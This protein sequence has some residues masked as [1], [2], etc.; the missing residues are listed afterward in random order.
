MNKNLISKYIKYLNNEIEHE[1]DLNELDAL[2]LKRDALTDLLDGRDKHSV[3]RVLELSCPDEEVVG[4]YECM[5]A[6]CGYTFM[7]EQCW[8]N[9]L[10]I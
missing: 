9:I 2:E 4:H 1:E 3:L 6:S 10:N 8:K 5:G 7:C